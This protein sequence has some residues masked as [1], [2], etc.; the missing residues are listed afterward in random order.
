MKEVSPVA[1]DVIAKFGGV[2]AVAKILGRSR[3]SV[4]R[5]THS[6][7]KGGRGGLVPA[8][9]QQPLLDAARELGIQLQPADFF[10][11]LPVSVNESC[12]EEQDTAA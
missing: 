11:E 8:D 10:E 2:E 5:W 12:S 9:F 1:R 3:M 6:R 4:Y 7:A